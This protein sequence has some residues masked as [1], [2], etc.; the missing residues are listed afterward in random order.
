MGA[1]ECNGSPDVWYRCTASGG[2][3][4]LLAVVQVLVQ[5]W[6]RCTASSGTLVQVYC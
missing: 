4:V 1:L 2:T 6:Y 3:G 5:Q